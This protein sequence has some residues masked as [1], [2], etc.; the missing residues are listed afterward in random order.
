MAAMASMPVRPSAAA[1]KASSIRA[2]VSAM[3]AMNS[4]RLVPKR[5]N[6]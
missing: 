3:V 2:C 1:R 6:R 4:S 5:R